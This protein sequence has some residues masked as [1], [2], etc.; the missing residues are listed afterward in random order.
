MAWESRR[1]NSY[2]YRKRK[3]GGKVV[4]EYIGTGFAALLAEQVNERVKA[5]A[6]AKRQEWQAI[7]DEQ[8][9]LDKMVND[10]GQLATAYADAV[11]LLNGHHLHKRQWRKKRGKSAGRE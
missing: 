1:N 4:S 7:R 2:Y 3:V 9:R 5:E 8:A 11:L 10:F 6:E